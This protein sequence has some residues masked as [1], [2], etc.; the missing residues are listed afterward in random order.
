MGSR[1]KDE[2]FS[3]VILKYH[4]LVQALQDTFTEFFT[5]IFVT[6]SAVNKNR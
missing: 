4:S 2:N 1:L 6:I 5:R 3:I